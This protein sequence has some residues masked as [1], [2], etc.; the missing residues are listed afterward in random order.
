M[1]KYGSLFCVMLMVGLVATSSQGALSFSSS[2]RLP[3]KTISLTHYLDASNQDLKKAL[4]IH[5]LIHEMP[6]LVN[7]LKTSMDM[8]KQKEVLERQ[9]EAMSTCHAKGLE[10]IFQEAGKVWGKMV[11]SYENKRQNEPKDQSKKNFLKSRND[12]LQERQRN[13]EITQGIMK[14]V[15]ADPKKWG[16][17][18]PGAS[19]DSWNDHATTFSENMEQEYDMRL[20]MDSVTKGSFSVDKTVDDMQ[21]DFA[22][23]LAKVGVDAMDLD[24]SKKSHYLKIQKQLKEAKK[25]AIV[26]AK[27]YIDLLEK[28]DSEHPELEQK[29]LMALERKRARLSD[30]AQ[31]AL[32]QSDGIV[33][34]SQMSPVM[35]Q[36]LIVA[37]L[38]KDSNALVYLTETN[39][40]EIDQ[41]IRE[42]QATEKIIRES[43]NQVDSVYDYQVKN[44]LP[45]MSKCSVF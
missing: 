7:V 38:E 5:N 31:Q 43:Q 27:K 30:A 36:K 39:A 22:K 21:Q 2:K 14:D 45:E 23:R 42:A 10:G 33:Q 34:I 19:F 15:S 12:R 28:Q 20:A 40:I 11:D 4:E 18:V 16:S 35:Q 17:T 41:R 37:A 32:E 25:D 13:M 1:T 3:P 9:I 29:R 44:V 6:D 24:L 8:T 26:E